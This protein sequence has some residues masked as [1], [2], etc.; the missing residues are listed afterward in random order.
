[1]PSLEQLQTVAQMRAQGLQNA[2]NTANTVWQGAQNRMAMEDRQ[3]KIAED[4]QRKQATAQAAQLYQAGDLKGAMGIMAQ[5]D[6][7]LFKGILTTFNPELQAQIKDA[8]ATPETVELGSQDGK[9]SEIYLLNPRTGKKQLIGPGISLAKARESA[10]AS[11]ETM[12]NK[13]LQ[14]EDAAN[15]AG[16]KEKALS[17]DDNLNNIDAAI[18]GLKE[19]YARSPGG[20]GPMATLG[21]ATKYFSKPTQELDAKFKRINLQQLT[22]MFQGMSKA[23]DSDA[24]RRAFEAQTPSI[25]NEDTVNADLLLGAKSIALKNKAELA[26][27]RGW[28]KDHGNLTDYD[29]PIIGKTRTVVSPDGKM[30]LVASDHYQDA[31]KEGYLDLDTYARS[32]ILRLKQTGVKRPNITPEQAR[33]ELK[34]RQGKQ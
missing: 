4:E 14:K 7:E 1:M 3:R 16:L 20:T 28:V 21:G 10:K 6:P 18:D 32:Q 29:S 23:I 24:E 31:L 8:T 15:F 22:S 26:A 30:E 34:R 9:S 5:H 13:T 2:Q 11:A 27:Q 12:F 33:E 17:V 19:Y 25:T